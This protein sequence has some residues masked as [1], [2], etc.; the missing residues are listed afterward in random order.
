MLTKRETEVLQGVIDKKGDMDALAEQFCIERNTIK[1]H[2]NH[3][4]KKLGVNNRVAMVVEG[5][6]R[7]YAKL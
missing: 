2:T 3:I 5:L 1:G 6:R 4:F 7:G